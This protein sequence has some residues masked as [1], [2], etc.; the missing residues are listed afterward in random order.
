[1]AWDE[2]LGGNAFTEVVQEI[3]KVFAFILIVLWHILKFSCCD[4]FQ[5]KSKKDPSKNFRALAKLGVAADKAKV[6]NESSYRPC[7]CGR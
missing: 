5:A 2:T 3:L 7:H 6:I 4:K 1:M